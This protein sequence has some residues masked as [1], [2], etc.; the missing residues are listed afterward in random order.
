MLVPTEKIS[1]QVRKHIRGF[2][3]VV[4]L[5]VIAFGISITYSTQLHTISFE[6]LN[7]A[8]SQT[9]TEN[10]ATVPFPIGVNPSLK[11]IVEQP[12]VDYYLTAHLTNQPTSPRHTSWLTKTLNKLAGNSWYQGLASPLNR[13]LVIYPGERKEQVAKNF[14]DILGWSNTEKVEFTDS[15]SDSVANLSEGMFFPDKYLVTKDTSSQQMANIIN[16]H[17]ANEVT[18]RY[19]DEVAELVPLADALTIASLL[20]REAYDFEDM[21]YISGVIWNRLF[22]DMNLQIDATLQY[23]KGTKPSTPVWWP[24]VRPV[25][26]Y[27]DS[28]FN[29]YQNE[30]LPPE[31]IA[32][33]SLDAIVAALNPRVTDC[34]FYFHDAD[35]Q[36]HC[37][38]TY[39]GHV[40]LLKQYYGRG[41]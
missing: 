35:S 31:P 40:A 2:Y 26:K 24:T 34:I 39:E 3:G 18:S 20:E 27:I 29:T 21:R 37:S 4:L 6:T 14:A 9:S 17:F 32:N 33:P 11:L 1:P 25:D 22:V 10:S 36:F 19:T 23:A 30:G 41:K 16:T 38:P 28:P 8:N 13:I 7:S 15:V 5:F 12:T